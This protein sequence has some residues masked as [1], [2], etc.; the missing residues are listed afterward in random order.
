[1]LNKHRILVVTLITIWTVVAC[2]RGGPRPLP[3]NGFRVA[4]E[5]H[6]IAPT[7]KKGETL[8]AEVTLKNLGQATW[9]SKPDDKN[10]Y[11]VHL[12]YHWLNKKEEAVV[13]EGVRTRLPHDLKG[14]ESVTL[15]A[16]IQ[17]PE[18]AGNYTL[19]V[20]MVQEAVAWF[21]ERGGD[22][23]LIPVSVS[24][25]PPLQEEASK[26]KIDGTIAD[27]RS[28]KPAKKLQTKTGKPGVSTGSGKVGD[29]LAS[30]LSKPTGTEPKGQGPWFVQVGSYADQKTAEAIAKKLAENGY[31]SY[32]KK[33]EV[34]GRVWHRVRVGRLQSRATAVILE[35]N[36]IEREHVSQTMI[37]K[38]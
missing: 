16:A 13:Y 14:G 27:S 18:N 3:Q 12:S 24:D 2:G 1:M 20:T 28:A 36:L 23:L 32:I 34:L 31:D 9:P 19:A 25:D 4:F 22:R 10:R 17:A 33:A 30:T 35:R 7:M 29:K 6:G 26:Q 37:A 15:K 21:S 8:F 5:S 11:A 38:Q